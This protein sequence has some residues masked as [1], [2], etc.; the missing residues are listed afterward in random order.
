MVPEI[1]KIMKILGGIDNLPMLPAVAVRLLEV[2]GDERS[3]AQDLAKLIET[4]Q[5]LAGKTMRMANSAYYGR[6]GKIANLRD[7]VALI[8]FRALRSTI[9]TVFFILWSLFIQKK[10][11][12]RRKRR[13]EQRRTGQLS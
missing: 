1:K 5:A 3:S 11:L 13:E 10:A 7:A 2:A 9:L 6:S 4:D 12:D 8:G